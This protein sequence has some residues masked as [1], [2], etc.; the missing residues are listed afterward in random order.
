MEDS[1]TCEY[2]QRK[3]GELFFIKAFD[4][5]SNNYFSELITVD[6]RHFESI[7]AYDFFLQYVYVVLNAGMKNQIAEKIFRRFYEN[8]FNT[9]L[10]GHLGKRKAIEEAKNK[11][12][13]WFRILCQMNNKID[14]LESLPWI[15][16]ITKFHLARNLGIDCAKP[17]RHLVRLAERFGFSDAQKMCCCLAEEFGM[18]V[19]TVDVVLWR[20]CNVFGSYTV[21]P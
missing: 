16:A 17:D 15:G 3:R 5:V 1:C 21:N 12:E 2:E 6:A 18:R 10:I 14:Y 11:Y 19:G 7:S 20:Y 13:D 8:G 9:K 4:F